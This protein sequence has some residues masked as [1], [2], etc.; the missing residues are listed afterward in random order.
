MTTYF[1]TRFYPNMSVSS[2]FVVLSEKDRILDFNDMV[3]GW[4]KAEDLLR[5]YAANVSSTD[6]T[7]KSWVI[8]YMWSSHELNTGLKEVRRLPVH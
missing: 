1:Q 8:E 4:V 3:R 2:G 5:T 6:L 7:T